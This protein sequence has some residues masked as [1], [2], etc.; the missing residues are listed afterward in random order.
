MKIIW[1]IKDGKRGH[2][3]Q[4]RGLIQALLKYQK[5]EVIEINVGEQGAT[6]LHFCLGLCPSFKNLKRPDLIL[7]A[8]SQTHPTILCASRK[9]GAPSVVLMSPPRLVRR[10][11]SLC[12]VPAHDR[13][14]GANVITSLGVLNPIQISSQKMP[15]QGLILLGGPSKHHDWDSQEIAHQIKRITQQNQKITWTA[16]T[17]RRSPEELTKQLSELGAKNLQVIPVEETNSTWLPEQLSRASYVW[18]TEDSVSMIYE[19]LSSG[20]K[21]GLL[22]VPRKRSAS[23]VIQGIGL[24]LEKKLVMPYDSNQCDLSSFTAPEPLNEAERIG[25]IINE[26][27][28]SQ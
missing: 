21:V 12:V 1:Q 13:Q 27:F 26:K 23:R 24:L 16:T 9:T 17:S 18:V 3:N 5:F 25:K 4:T 10:Y 14:D 15:E 7:G 19:A 2:E 8:G 20:A 28:L 22:P 11:F 6:W